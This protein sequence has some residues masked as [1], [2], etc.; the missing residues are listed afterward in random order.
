MITVSIQGY[1]KLLA[2]LRAGASETASSMQKAISK[3]GLITQRDIKSQTPVDTGRLQ[4]G[5]VLTIG[6][7]TAI[8][9]NKVEYGPYVHNGT[10]RFKGRPFMQWG[11]EQAMPEIQKVLE[12]EVNSILTLITK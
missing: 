10:K 7:L 4:K 5:N 12:T 1:D 9:T 8:I 6:P 2:G 3:I 11:V